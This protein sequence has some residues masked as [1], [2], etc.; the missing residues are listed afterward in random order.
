MAKV[1]ELDVQLI[2]ATSFHA[3]RGVEWEV[4]EGASDSEALVEFSGRACYESFDKPNPRTASNQAYL[5]HILE[6]GHDALLE[7]ATATLYIR[8]LSRSATHELVRHRHFSFSQLSQRFV[9]PEETEVVLPKL[10]AEDEQLTRLTLQAADDARFVYEE[11]LDALESKLD[12]EPN[13]LLRKKQA[14]QAARA[15]LPNLTESR[16]VVT[17]NYRAW[18]HFIGARATE[19][20][21]TE[22]RQLAVTCLKLLREQSPVL[23]DDFTITTLAD[24]TEMASSPYA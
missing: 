3:P 12:Q 1:T 11:L 23:F 18:R 14:R 6:V 16:I 21:D 9:H 20:A 4:D 10:I 19:Q 8:G 2:A 22:L 24:G 5:H 13:A 15:V 7:H 17:G